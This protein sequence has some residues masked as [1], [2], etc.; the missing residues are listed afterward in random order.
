[1]MMGS[2][3][4]RVALVSSPLIFSLLVAC[5]KPA[6]PGEPSDAGAH[7]VTPSASA[8]AVAASSIAP[9]ASAASAAS[10]TWSGT[11]KSVAGS[12][13]YPTDAP[14]GKEWK[15]MKWQGDDASVGL[16]EGAMS[17]AIDGAGRV[18]GT[19]EGPLG[20]VTLNG[21][22]EKDQLTARVDRKDSDRGLTGT[23]I[24]K[25]AGDKLEGTM[26]LSLAEANVF[27]A[28]TFTLTKK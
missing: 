8:S 5:E 20:P 16:G 4:A 13:Y 3:I 17:V 27:R 2:C 11:Y 19:A 24:G 1:V 15:D 25:V 10:G 26:R 21:M 7:A 6:P 23:A 22:L 9:P 14:N 18:T 12:L 28:A